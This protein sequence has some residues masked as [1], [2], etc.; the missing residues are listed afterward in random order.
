MGIASTEGVARQ[1]LG[2]RAIGFDQQRRK[3]LGLGLVAKAVNKILGRKLV[4]RRGLVAQQ[5][6]HRVVVL[7]VCQAPQLRILCRAPT[8]AFQLPILQR[9]RQLDAR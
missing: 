8:L 9:R 6:A 1:P 4:R 7:A 3:T 2:G 5:I